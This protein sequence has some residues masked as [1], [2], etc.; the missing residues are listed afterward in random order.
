LN[1]TSTNAVAP[2]SAA[3]PSAKRLNLCCLRVI[4]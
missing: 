2:P 4:A 3:I 1:A